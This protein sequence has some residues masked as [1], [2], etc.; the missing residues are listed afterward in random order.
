VKDS[1]LRPFAI[2]LFAVL[3]AF[4]C[5]CSDLETAP[6]G[7]I[8]YRLDIDDAWLGYFPGVDL[9]V[10]VDTSASMAEEQ[11]ILASSLHDLVV[12]LTAPTGTGPFAA[13][14]E[15]RFAVVTSNMGLSS[16]GEE[17]DAS[18][19]GEVP[20]G[21]TG[22]GDDGMF[23]GIK[24]VE[25]IIGGD[26]VPCPA[27]D[28]P[29]V[30]TSWIQQVDTPAVQAACL[31]LQ[32]MDGCMI[33]QPLQAAVTAFDREDQWG[34]TQLKH[35][36]AV[37]IVSDADDCSM[38]NGEAL[39]AESEIADPAEMKAGLACGEHPEH[40]FPASHLYEALT[41]NKYIGGVVFAAITGVPNEGIGADT[42]QGRGDQ[43][44]D[45]LEQDAMQL[46]P[47]QPNA[48]DNLAWSFRPACTR[49]ADS[50][51]VTR[52]EPGRRFVELAAEGFGNLGYVSSICNADWGPAM[53]GL[54]RLIVAHA[55]VSCFQWALP[56]D[57]SAKTSECDLTVE[58]INEGE[59]CPAVFGGAYPTI[60]KEASDDGEETTYMYC[61]LPKLPTELECGDMTD[62]QRAAIAGGFGWF[63]CENLGDEDFSEAC[64]DGVDNDGDG[65]TDCGDDQ[66]SDCAPCPGATGSDCSHACQYV[67]APTNAVR[68]EVA[69]RQLSM[70]CFFADGP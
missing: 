63:Y 40:L 29:W 9:L 32:G 53:D 12:A 48:P 51:E 50:E 44:G 67:V 23:Q 38:L 64:D 1:C 6:A 15:L 57:A 19:P 31:A 20:A 70:S 8:S 69:G 42:C 36:L 13:I 58:Y 30:E 34:F 18:W 17:N 28:A 16:D 68:T 61:P 43:L 41:E 21:C 22:L 33:R 65:L 59:T 27:L 24:A 2:A 62:A 45:C 54:A 37:L 56:W 46:V 10:V 4:G 25:A 39:F 60:K 52:A 66:C 5:A 11:A 47:E 49:S 55:W 3:G 7:P 26:G 14:D 35:L